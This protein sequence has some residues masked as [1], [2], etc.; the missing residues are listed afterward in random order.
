M[1][2]E[3]VKDALIGRLNQRDVSVQSVEVDA[4][5]VK[6]DFAGTHFGD[7]L[8]ALSP[9]PDGYLLSHDANSARV[10]LDPRIA[11]SK[12]V[13]KKVI[14]VRLAVVQVVE[15]PVSLDCVEEMKADHDNP[16]AA[17]A[18][19]EEIAGQLARVGYDDGGV[20]PGKGCK[21]VRDVTV[22]ELLPGTEEYDLAV[23]GDVLSVKFGS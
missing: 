8:W 3:D 4:G 18:T 22:H 7:V 1:K 11:I 9:L 17:E 12:P 13:P 19:D 21:I 20:T 5:E 10:Y 6:I 14:M 2:I 15:V 23:D 16:F